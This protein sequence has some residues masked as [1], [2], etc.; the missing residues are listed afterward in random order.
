MIILFSIWAG[1]GLNLLFKNFDLIEKLRMWRSVA[2]IV[3]LTVF[4]PVFFI[5]DLVVLLLDIITEEEEHEE[6][7]CD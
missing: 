5:Y 4:A 1:I 7:D 3:T 2:F 6:E